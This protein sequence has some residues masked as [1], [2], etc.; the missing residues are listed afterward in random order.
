MKTNPLLLIVSK[1]TETTKTH[2]LTVSLVSQYNHWMHFLLVFEHV[3]QTIHSMIYFL[4]Y[5]QRL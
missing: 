5:I 4:L 3:Y 1:L 2:P